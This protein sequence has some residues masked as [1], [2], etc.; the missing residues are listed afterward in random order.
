[1]DKPVK[2]EKRPGD[3][4][5]DLAVGATER[6]ASEATL[7]ETSIGQC[8]KSLK[9]R[10]E[11][12][13]FQNCADEVAAI[14]AELL[15]LDDKLLMTV[16]PHVTRDLLDIAG[17]LV[18][19]GLFDLLEKLMLKGIH[20]IQHHNQALVADWFVPLNNLSALYEMKGDYEARDQI[21]SNI[22]ALAEQLQAPLDS[23][24]ADV[25]ISLADVYNRVGHPKA[26]IILYSQLYRYVM[27]DQGTTEADTRV[28]FIFKYSSL[29]VRDGQLEA[30]IEMCEQSLAALETY[31]DITVNHR[32]Q[33][34]ALTGQLAHRKGDL[35]KAQALLE[36]ARDVAEQSVERYSAIA[37]DVYH[38]LAVLYFQRARYDE[39][40]GLL[41]RALHILKLTGNSSTSR[42]A[43]E[44]GML[45]NV[46]SEKGEL[47]RAEALYQEAFHIYE[48]APDTN[49]Q[50]F[51][52]FLAGAGLLY[53]K[54]RRPE[55]AVDVFE[56]M[57]DIRESASGMP[58]MVVAHAISYLATAHFQQN[59]FK[60]A[61]T[62]YR[63]AIDLR[64]QFIQ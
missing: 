29:L 42:Y 3:Q 24:T 63:K 39:A 43:G 9:F 64:H 62:L 16:D 32:L 34:L 56:R 15:S 17:I 25:F 49:L 33:V 58:P 11:A 40:E 47:E 5:E 6:H 13:D 53:L 20:I 8:V 21:C 4:L 19:T 23:R 28:G 30:A 31:S 45:A 18:P 10:V 48:S 36:Q 12:I 7:D 52:D 26:A 14:I 51:A 57:K 59:N 54:L 60:E 61:I 35:D 50:E 44:T 46:L 38:N 22:V 55:E 41:Q 37:G 2:N 27:S 1:M